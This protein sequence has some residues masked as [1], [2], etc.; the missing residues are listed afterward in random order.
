MY[1]RE[2]GVP[3]FHAVYGE[4]DASISIETL[5]P[6]GGYLP[7]RALRLVRRWAAMH[8]DELQENWNLAEQGEVLVSIA[9]LP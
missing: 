3:H 8:L 4:Y 9:P 5:D 1:Y 2:H 7:P 6:L